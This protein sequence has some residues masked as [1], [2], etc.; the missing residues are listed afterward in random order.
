MESNGYPVK[1]VGGVTLMTE[2]KVVKVLD[3][4]ITADSERDAYSK[5]H[6][7]LSASEPEWSVG[8]PVADDGF[9]FNP[10][11]E[12]HYHRASCDDSGGNLMCGFPSD[13]PTIAERHRLNLPLKRPDKP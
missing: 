11:A 12:Q 1:G 5:A 4:A 6:R 2:R 8:E 9:P 3:L 13:G 10:N 7:M